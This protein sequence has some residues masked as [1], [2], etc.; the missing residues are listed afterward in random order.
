MPLPFLFARCFSY[1]ENLRF[2]FLLNFVPSSFALS[3][4]FYTPSL[5]NNDFCSKSACL[6]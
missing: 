2:S 1:A 6:V 5:A 3:E 4:Y